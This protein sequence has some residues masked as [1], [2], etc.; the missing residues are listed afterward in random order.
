MLP[1]MKPVLPSNLTLP[2]KTKRQDSDVFQA[3]PVS[4]ITVPRVQATNIIGSTINDPATQ[5]INLPSQKLP[6][7]PAAD[8]TPGINIHVTEDYPG[9]Y[10]GSGS[11]QVC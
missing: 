5:Y 4:K 8:L 10:N 6:V 9:F 11:L 2:I 7:L 1:A 3:A